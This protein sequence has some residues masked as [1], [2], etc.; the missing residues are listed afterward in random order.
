MRYLSVVNIVFVVPARCVVVC[1]M[2]FLL[3]APGMRYLSA[4]FFEFHLSMSLQLCSGR[5]FDTFV[6][7]LR[8]LVSRDK[9]FQEEALRLMNRVSERVDEVK[10]NVKDVENNV[11]FLRVEVAGMQAE[12]VDRLSALEASQADIGRQLED[13]LAPMQGNMVLCPPFFVWLLSSLHVSVIS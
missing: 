5:I 10:T 9:A 13:I 6:F 8:L 3:S 7:F 2:I 12:V 1:L 4:F 11:T